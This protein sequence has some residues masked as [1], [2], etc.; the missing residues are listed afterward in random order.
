MA[1]SSNRI[2]AGGNLVGAWTVT[3]TAGSMAV[4]TTYVYSLSGNI[5]K[6][7]VTRDESGRYDITVEGVEDN[8]AF[9]TFVET[10]TSV[11]AGGGI[12]EL[13]FED[14]TKELATTSTNSTLAVA[15]KG[16]LSGGV[17]GAA[18]KYGVFPQRIKNT[19]GS[20]SQEGE[21]YNRPTLEFEGY[22]LNGALTF[23]S[24]YFTDFATTAAAITLTTS[25]PYGTYVYA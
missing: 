19:S 24:S 6:T 2:L 21:K 23:A 11:S 15:V 7:D 14:G 25:L 20:W 8:S 9:K 3:N 5:I 22:K 16:G 12:E 13:L 17:S 4:G 18:R 1:G 10:Y